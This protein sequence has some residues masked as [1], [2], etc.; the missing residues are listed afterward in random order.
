M[1]NRITEL[2]IK[3]SKNILSVYFTAGYPQLNDTE[4]IISL[5]E[6]SGADMIEIGIPFSDPLADGE[7]IQ[8]SSS[9]ALKN[10]MTLNILF[11]QLRDIRKEVS[12]PLILMG[13]LNPILQYGIEKFVNKC[14]ETGIDG[15][16]IPDLPP[17]I[18]SEQ[19]KNIF[20]QNNLSNIILITPDTKPERVK[21]LDSMSSGF[22]YLVSSS[23]TTGSKASLN[24][25][26]F[27]KINMLEI[28]NPMMIGFGISDNE[29]FLKAC[30]LGNGAIIGSAFI[31]A[32]STGIPDENIPNFINSILKNK[33]IEL[34]VNE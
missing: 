5:L 11:R 14:V 7:I 19:Y 21:L 32:I 2:F 26:S 17:E 33:K 8:K 1:K 29:S 34:I 25:S 16:I 27:S 9:Q 28:N 4:K 3:R 22:L 6:S 23:S 31:K 24:E 30:S 18:Y 15:V 10:G 12:L 20:E 13:Y